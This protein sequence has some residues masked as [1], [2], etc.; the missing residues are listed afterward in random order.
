MWRG[1]V[2]HPKPTELPTK[3]Q[4]PRVRHLVFVSET[5][6]IMSE[7]VAIMSEACFPLLQQSPELVLFPFSGSNYSL[8]LSLSDLSESADIIDK[9]GSL[10][11]RFTSQNPKP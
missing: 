10:V 7:T 4:C 9:R 2:P 5:V 3:K 1:F 11:R 8:T 6:A